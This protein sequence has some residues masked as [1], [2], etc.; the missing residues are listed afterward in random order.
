MASGLMIGVDSS[1]DAARAVLLDGDRVLASVQRLAPPA[2]GRMA[3]VLSDLVAAD[4]AASGARG[5]A[6]A[7]SFFETSL[8][9]R[10]GL[11]RVGCVR[12]A[13]SEDDVVPPLFG[14][15]ADLLAVV[16]GGTAVLRGGCA[17]DGART[18]RPSDVHLAAVA[19]DLTE[20]GVR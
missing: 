9:R 4:P 18:D 19:A 2:P 13:A 3:D 1:E 15:P 14:W 17:Y 12:L 16:R 8:S 5:V 6:V 10:V 20:Q 7:T 11:A